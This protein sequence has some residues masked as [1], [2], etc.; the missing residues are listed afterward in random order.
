M[1]HS[2]LVSKPVGDR[3]SCIIVGLLSAL[4]A[5]TI[6]CFFIRLAFLL[7]SSAV[8]HPMSVIRHSTPQECLE[9][10]DVGSQHETSKVPLD[11]TASFFDESSRKSNCSRRIQ[12]DALDW[13]SHL[14]PSS[15]VLSNHPLARSKY[16][17]PHSGCWRST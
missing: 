11:L 13:T 10:W 5:I 8:S 1:N 12:N 9:V 17:R 4:Y 6:S 2:S 14:C 16:A 15:T 3:G 7:L